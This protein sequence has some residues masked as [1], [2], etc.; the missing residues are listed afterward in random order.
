MEKLDDL[1]LEQVSGGVN[2]CFKYTVVFGDTLY[3]L[4]KR[5]DTTVTILQRLNN[6]EDPDKI[7][8]GR[9]LIIPRW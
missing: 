7:K 1:E 9:N 4:A 8:A 5:F 6:I 2:D 3:K